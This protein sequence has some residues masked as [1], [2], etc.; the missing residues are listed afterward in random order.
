MIGN[1]VSNGTAAPSARSGKN[2][3]C[4][5]LLHQTS[6]E[7]RQRLT[8]ASS[9]FA[10]QPEPGDPRESNQE[11]PASFRF[12]TAYVLVG[13]ADWVHDALPHSDSFV[14]AAILDR[15]LDRRPS[16]TSRGRHG[17]CADTGL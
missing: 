2:E 12:D 6:D 1:A 3:T 5:A 16:S 9:L 4:D 7:A 8:G 10:H 11:T 14:A 17:A 15:L 13:A